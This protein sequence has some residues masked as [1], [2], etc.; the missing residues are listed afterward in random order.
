VEGRDAV[1]DVLI[2]IIPKNK[3]AVEL[4]VNVGGTYAQMFEQFLHCIV[5]NIKASHWLSLVSYCMCL[6]SYM[7]CRSQQ[8]IKLLT[9]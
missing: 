2:K 1:I 8:G 9:T 7:C 3:L 4:F 5:C 6:V